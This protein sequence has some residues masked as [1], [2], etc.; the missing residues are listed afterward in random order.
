MNILFQSRYQYPL[1]ESGGLGIVV[2]ELMKELPSHCAKLEHW[3]WD[4]HTSSSTEII[5]GM[6]GH[7]PIADVAVHDPRLSLLL[8]LELTNLSMIRRYASPTFDFDLVHAHTWEVSLAAVIAKYIK[9]IPLVYTTHDIMKN[10]AHDE[11]NET[12]DIYEH[13]VLCEK[14]MMSEA[15]RI[16]AV[17]EEN[18]DILTS[19][20]P[21]VSSKTV[22]IPNGVDTQT[23]RPE[24]AAPYSDLAPGYL[25]FIGR[26]VPS[27]GIEAIVSMLDYIDEDVQMVFALSTKRWDGE[28]HPNADEYCEMIE[29]LRRRRPKTKLIINEWRRD[30]VAGLYANASITLA[31]SKYEP[32]GMVAME[33]QACGTPVI[34]NRIGFMK[35]SV[36]SG[37]NGLLLDTDPEDPMYPKAMAD[38]VVSLIKDYAELRRMGLSSR[39][40]VVDNHSWVAR[41]EQHAR[42]YQELILGNTS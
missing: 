20:Y 5:A 39:S 13:G 35:D 17:S 1:V 6:V 42:L 19:F 32:C 4:T 15:D 37:M 41:A 8:D 30:V 36:Q 26:T 21:E 29:M 18:R 3:T 28:K 25:L 33:S 2:Y 14:I 27:K 10:D 24:A 40:N 9:K 12:A 23:F 31:P 22:V 38:A 11:L 7:G 16:V 34:T